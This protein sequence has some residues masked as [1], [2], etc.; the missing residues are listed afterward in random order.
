MTL[1]SQ[2]YH[3]L[4]SY[5]RGKMPQHSLDWQNQPSTF[6]TYPKAE[7]IELPNEFSN[8]E[9]KLSLLLK[10]SASE[11][12]CVVPKLADLSEIFALAYSITGR[13]AHQG[14]YFHYRSVA[15]A[16][17][18]Y[19]VEIYVGTKDVK[20]LP[21]GIYHYAVARHALSAIRNGDVSNFVVNALRKIPQKYPTL[22]FFTCWIRGIL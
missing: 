3:R 12:K 4:T 11:E 14:G 13:T 5:Q 2:Q 1:N 20:G 10:S 9:D 19:P 6:K 15:S 7:L 17:A 16:G 8:R 21:D 22:V 18:L